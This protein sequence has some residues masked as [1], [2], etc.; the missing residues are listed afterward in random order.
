MSALNTQEQI[1]TDDDL[2]DEGSSSN[3][4]EHSSSDVTTDS[5]DEIP[6]FAN[7]KPYDFEPTCEPRYE[8]SKDNNKENNKIYRAGNTDWCLCGKCKVMATEEESCCCME[9]N[10]VPEKYFEGILIYLDVFLVH[11]SS[12]L[13]MTL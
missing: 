10:E 9:T 3:E 7:L 11:P 12:V 2:S 5:D 6:N 8:V 13:A 4:S 1:Y